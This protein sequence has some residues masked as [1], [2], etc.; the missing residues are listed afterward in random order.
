MS[1]QPILPLSGYAGWNYLQRTQEAQQEVFNKSPL[2]N[3][4]IEHFKENISKALTADALVEDRTLLK[5]A[6][7]AFGL[8]DDLNKQA[9]VKKA[10][11]EGTDNDDAFANR[12]VDPAYRKLADEFGYG[13]EFG[14]RVWQSDFANKLI[15][16][17]QER[18]FEQ[19]VGQSDNAMRMAMN[20]KREIGDIA[21]GSDPQ[22]AGWFSVM[23]STP[24]RRV[25]EGAL[26]V[27]TAVGSLDID[28]QRE[29][30]QDAAVKKFGSSSLDVF[31]ESDKV[32]LAVRD[33][34]IRE[35]VKN[36]PSSTAPGTAALTMLQNASIG[37]QAARNL[38]NSNL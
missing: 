5:V 21:A 28:R 18:Q 14:A 30:F 22:N 35:Q 37:L 3:R 27:P 34:L 31:L 23:G 29:I 2:L 15:D 7:G 1:F 16:M 9:F 17:Y 25:L 26:G 10:L 33:F 36:G 19:A 20:F 12:L 4:E 24:L 6:L 8:D 38:F 13:N 32:E 11:A